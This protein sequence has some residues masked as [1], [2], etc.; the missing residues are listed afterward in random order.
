MGVDLQESDKIG[1]SGS[2]AG[3]TSK[4]NLLLISIAALMSCAGSL[5]WA[6]QAATQADVLFPLPRL[7]HVTTNLGIATFPV[8]FRPEATTDCWATP[9]MPAQADS[10]AA[11][12]AESEGTG[13]DGANSD[14]PENHERAISGKLLIPNAL[15]DQKHIWTFPAGVVRGRHWKPAFAFVTTTVGLVALDPYEAPYFRTTTTFH[16]F[17]Q[18]FSSNATGIALV[19]MPLSFYGVSLA[20]HNIY[21]QHTS[22][23]VAESVLDAE[24]VDA[25]MKTAFRRVRPRDVPPGGNFADTFFEAGGGLFGGQNSFPSGHAIA[26]FSIATIFADRYSRHRWVP[27]LAYGLAATIGFSRITTQSHFTSDVFVGAVL[28]YSISHYV[29]LQR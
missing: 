17:N 12:P 25:V 6:Q 27:W 5:A 24:L 20:R 19:I 15:E 2:Q 9:L 1:L 4:R 13:Q 26:A 14:G 11:P 16:G 18:V 8:A 22:L 3:A 23:L 29:V 28:G 21:D 7:F 10:A